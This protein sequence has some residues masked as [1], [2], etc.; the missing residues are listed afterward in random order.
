ME[1]KDRKYK[2]SFVGRKSDAIGITYP[3]TIEIHIPDF[4]ISDELED[5]ALMAI[6]DNGYDHVSKV[7]LEK[8]ES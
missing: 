1:Y 4:I 2:V 6:Y 5:F 7:S 3:I 8:G